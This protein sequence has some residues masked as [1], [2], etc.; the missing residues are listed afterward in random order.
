M[1]ETKNSESAGV[2]R[3]TVTKAMAWAVPAVAV[4]ATVPV[5]S[6]S[7]IPE[8]TQSE[9]SCKCPGQSTPNEF[10]YYLELCAGGISCPDSSL[11]ITVTKIVKR[12]SG[13]ILWSGS[14]VIETGEC[15]VF[16]GSSTDS[17]T[18]IDVTYSI[19]D[20]EQ[21]LLGLQSPPNCD[22]VDDPIETCL[23]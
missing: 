14:Q 16:T 20:V 15:S 18:W 19:G 10:T 8:L 1:T 9:R 5:A 7:G 22:K 13:D 6:A 17:G 23:E 3:R 21:P 11:S 4:A 2:S 12:N